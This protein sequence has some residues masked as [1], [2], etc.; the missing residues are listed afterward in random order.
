M[1]NAAGSVVH[2]R[3]SHAWSARVAQTVRNAGHFGTLTGP[4]STNMRK[5]LRRKQDMVDREAEFHLSAYKASG[6]ELIMGSGSF[7]G[8][9][10]NF[11][12][13]VRGVATMSFFR[14]WIR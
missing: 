13:G 12:A 6:V 2:A 8:P 5:V 10:T 4:V 9:K 11:P 1:S 3:P 7:V 14:C